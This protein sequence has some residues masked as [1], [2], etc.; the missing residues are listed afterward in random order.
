[1][2]LSSED[3]HEMMSELSL[4]TI[5]IILILDLSVDVWQGWEQIIVFEQLLLIHHHWRAFLEYRHKVKVTI[6][7][8]L[9]HSTHEI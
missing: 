7:Y 5:V 9:L 2:V 4:I 8:L 6:F 3:V 1:V